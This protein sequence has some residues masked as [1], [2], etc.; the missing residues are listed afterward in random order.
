MNFFYKFPKQRKTLFVF[1]EFIIE[2]IKKTDRNLMGE[3]LKEI[4]NLS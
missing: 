1:L 4:I 2:M 3:I